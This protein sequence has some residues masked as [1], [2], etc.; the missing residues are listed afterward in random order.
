MIYILDKNNTM[1]YCKFF[2]DS[3]ILRDFQYKLGNNKDI[4]PFDISNKCG[5]VGKGGL[6]YTDIQNIMNYEI[7]GSMIGIIEIPEGVPIVKMYDK[8]KSPEI[9]IIELYDYNEFLKREDL[10]TEEKKRKKFL[11]WDSF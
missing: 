2:P 1:V 7:Y 4:H 9:N 6:Y 5:K 10:Y 8:Y 3:L 11:I